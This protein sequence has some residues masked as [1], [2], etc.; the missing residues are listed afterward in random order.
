MGTNYYA[1]PK[2][3]DTEKCVLKELVDIEDFEQLAIELPKE[4]HIGKSSMGWCF[5]LHVLPEY[6]LNSLDEWVTFLKNCNIRNEN[7]NYITL[8]ELLK[9]ITKRE[10]ETDFNKPFKFN[11]FTPY[12]NWKEFFNSNNAEPGPK[13]LLRSQIDGKRCIGHGK[14]TYDYI[15][16]EFS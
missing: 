15:T 8:D 14:G 16:G 12:K 1:I 2:I 5:S 4:Y 13:G 11:K 9:V 6:N 10:N 7:G 3:S